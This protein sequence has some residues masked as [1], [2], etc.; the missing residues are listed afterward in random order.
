MKKPI[1]ILGSAVFL[2]CS[3]AAYCNQKTQTQT[4]MVEPYYV[5]DFNAVNCF[6]DIRVNDVSVFSW[7]VDGQMAT[8]IPVNH[9]I[10]ESGNQR[11]SYHILPSSGELSLQENT[12]FEA[13]VLLYD[14]GGETFEPKEEVTKFKMPENTSGTPLPMYQHKD[15]FVAEVPYTLNAWQN[16]QDL[17]EIE[18]LRELVVAAFRKIE[19]L[20]GNGQY[21]EF[22][23]LFQQREDNM[24]TCFYLT[25]KEKSKRMSRLI[26]ELKTELYVVVPVS[27]ED[28]MVVSGH[29]KLVTLKKQDGSSALLLRNQEGEEL[30]LEIRL[31]LEQ[32]K[33]ELSII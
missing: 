10:P 29:G 8:H 17:T 18:N 16:S 1:I 23:A 2:L 21:D 30:N 4:K 28:M 6:I 12:V 11:I 32:N 25:E 24:A 19:N 26:D 13:T 14:T 5:I 22:I 15:F 27:E 7:N 33:T 20:I 3:T 31:H 9:A